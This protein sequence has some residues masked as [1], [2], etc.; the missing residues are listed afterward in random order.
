MKVPNTACL[1]APRARF[2]FKLVAFGSKCSFYLEPE[3]ALWEVET[4]PRPHHRQGAQLCSRGSRSVRDAPR[5]ACP[6]GRPRTEQDCRPTPRRKDH[7]QRTTNRKDW[8]RRKANRNNGGIVF[9]CRVFWVT[10]GQRETG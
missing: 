3:R 10:G 6:Q 1:P 8:T 4:T 7:A 9:L 5:R 2:I